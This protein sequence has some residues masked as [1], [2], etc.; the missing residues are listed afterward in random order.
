MTSVKTPVRNV[1]FKKPKLGAYFL[2]LC[3]CSFSAF[4]RAENVRFAHRRIVNRN[5][6]ILEVSICVVMIYIYI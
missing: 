4:W 3:M 1:T 5:F 2:C 6:G